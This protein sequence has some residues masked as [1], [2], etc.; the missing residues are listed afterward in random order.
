MLSLLITLL[1]LLVLWW[2]ATTVARAFNAPPQIL[3]VLN[4]LFVVIAVLWLLQVF[5]LMA[6]VPLLH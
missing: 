2:A 5:G 1:V 3:T 6:R 4:V